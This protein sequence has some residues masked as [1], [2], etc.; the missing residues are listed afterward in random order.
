MPII[1]LFDIF[2]AAHIITGATGLITFWVPVIGLKGG[3]TH[4]RWGRI[5]ARALF[6]TG[7]S[8]IGM[9]FCTLAYPLEL[10]P[11]IA[12]AALV[13]GMFGWMMLYLATLT[14][15][16]ASYG[17]AAVQQKRQHL[18][19]RSWRRLL[20][21]A[22]V[23]LTALNCAVQGL[24]IGQVLMVG[25]SAIGIASAITN[26]VYIFNDRPERQGYLKQHVKALVG[27]GISVYTAFLAFGAARM[28]PQH[29]FNP[30]LWATPV[31][32]GIS[33]IVWHQRRI[34]IQSKSPVRF[35]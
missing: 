26:A 29:A 32:L 23:L 3:Q 15:S 21:E 20:L 4:K 14:V 18:A 25:I 19:H 7:L 11:K 28:L 5:F 33:L 30:V 16:L 2:L 24:L 17:I 22:A 13:R 27:A 31:V 12:D 10:H 34:S 1:W 35:G 6:V 9:S 8:A